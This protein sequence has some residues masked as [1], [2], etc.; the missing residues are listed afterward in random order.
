[1]AESACNAGDPG[2]IQHW[3]DPLETGMA[4]LSCILAWEV[5]RTEEHGGLYSPWGLKESDTTEHL[6]FLLFFPL[7]IECLYVHLCMCMHE[8]EI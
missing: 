7:F 4:T 3:E 6:S 8:C 1:M 5:P 2:S